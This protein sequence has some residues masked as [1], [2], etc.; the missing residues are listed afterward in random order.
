MV[1]EMHSTVFAIH[2]MYN[3]TLWFFGALS[4]QHTARS[5]PPVGVRLFKVSRV[6]DVPL[7]TYRTMI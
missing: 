5:A 3:F 6:S 7:W 1:E 4:A 2:S